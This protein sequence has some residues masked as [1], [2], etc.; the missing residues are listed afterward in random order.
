MI[1]PYCI[2]LLA[3]RTSRTA[4][5]AA[6]RPGVLSQPQGRG[7]P[8]KYIRLVLAPLKSPR[9]ENE[10]RSTELGPGAVRIEFEDFHKFDVL[11]GEPLTQAFWIQD[12]FEEGVSGF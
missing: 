10:R 9:D 7:S 5:G 1:H 6:G 12:E 8:K 11:C 3:S 4:R 2:L